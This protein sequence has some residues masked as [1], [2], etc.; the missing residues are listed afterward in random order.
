[1]SEINFLLSNLKFNWTIIESLA[2]LFSIIY[3]VLAAKQNIWCWGF[4]A[5]S[6]SLFIYICFISQ[7]FAET[8]LQF[9]Y[10]FMAGYG[11]YNWNKS[12][13]ELNIIQLDVSKHLLI[14]LV[15]AICTFLIGF[16]FANFT[17]AKT[18]IIDS[19][20]T[21][22]SV[23]ATY[24]VTKKVLENWLYWIIIDIVSVNLY[25]NRDLHLTSLLF[26]AYTFIAIFGYFSWLK[27][28]KVNA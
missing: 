28:V 4:A 6:V 9:F 26:I 7:L 22:F 23:I 15:G 11:Y 1:M 12:K 16:Y 3:V 20:T 10:L 21:V 27:K 8:L 18:P 2:V 24:M 25:F 19:F 14:I 17:E 13:Q 5:V